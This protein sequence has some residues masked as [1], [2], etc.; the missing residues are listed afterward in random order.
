MYLSSSGHSRRDFNFFGKTAA[1]LFCVVFV[2]G[3]GVGKSDA[4]APGWLSGWTN[5]KEITVS[6]ANVG[7]T[8]LVNFPLLVKITS[9]SD[10]SR[11]LASGADI[12]FTASDG[13]TILSYERESWSGGNGS[14]ATATFWV[15]VPTISYT[16]DTTIYIYYGNSSASDGQNATD[17]WD[18]N[19]QGVWHL[20]SSLTTDSTSNANSGTNSG[21]TAAGDGQIYGG[22]IFSPGTI[23]VTNTISV[24][25]FTLST[26]FESGT[27]GG[28]QTFL[29]KEASD[30]GGGDASRNYWFGLDDH[31]A[32]GVLYSNNKS[33]DVGN[34]F[35]TSNYIDNTWHLAEATYDGTTIS[36]YVDGVLAA[37]PLPAPA[38]DTQIS[39]TTFG[40]D[41]PDSDQY[42]GELNEIH[43]SNIARSADWIN[44]EYCNE[45]S[46]ASSHCTVPAGGYASNEISL[47]KQEAPAP[48]SPP[49]TPAPSG[50]GGQIVGSGPYAPSAAGMYGYTSP[51]PQIIY[52][53]GHVVYLDVAGSTT[54]HTTVQVNNVTN[55]SQFVSS[56]ITQQLSFGMSGMQVLTLQKYLNSIGFTVAVTGPGSSG[57]ETSLYG[58]ATRAAIIRFQKA[59]NITPTGNVGPLTRKALDS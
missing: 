50:G 11:A 42:A 34:L 9:D 47:G 37:G 41:P 46:S 1:I 14:A 3:V 59:H 27:D 40:N 15:R 2:F 49:T 13:T 4:S 18:S 17:V 57:H 55:Q 8:N 58:F 10:L 16:N 12:R 21:V 43:I 29:A 51:R 20:G 36:I 28:Y 38:P 25:N 56:N 23:S 7:S 39:H 48:A 6:H 33:P 5:R 44:F 45:M 26:W 24:P 31:G 35:S 54:P 22:G 32:V 53:D 19:Y 30:Y 52:P